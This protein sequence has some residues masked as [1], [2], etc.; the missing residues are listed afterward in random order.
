MSSHAQPPT[1]PNGIVTCKPGTNKSDPNLALEK[2][3]D[4]TLELPALQLANFFV[5]V[6]M[7]FAAT[8]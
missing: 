8:R 6:Y 4:R 2:A 7:F 5:R 3:A 1:T